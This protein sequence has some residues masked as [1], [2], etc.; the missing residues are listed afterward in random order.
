MTYGVLVGDT[1]GESMVKNSSSDKD[2]TSVSTTCNVSWHKLCSASEKVLA[3]TKNFAIERLCPIRC[4]I[5][6]FLDSI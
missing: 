6:L 1:V 3:L 2:R 4:L 5:T